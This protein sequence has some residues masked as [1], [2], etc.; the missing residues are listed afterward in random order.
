MNPRAALFRLWVYGLAALLL[1][2]CAFPLAW[3]VLTSIKPDREILT[4]VP[5]FIPSELTID[6]YRRLFTSTIFATYFR[7]SIIVA[8]LATLLTVAVGTLAAYGITR[9]RFR[10]REAPSVIAASSRSSGIDWK[11][12]RSSHIENGSEK[13]A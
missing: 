11:K 6:A 5:T 8:G 4:A 2:I 9:F 13:V 1:V 3:M 10:G 7:N 12:E